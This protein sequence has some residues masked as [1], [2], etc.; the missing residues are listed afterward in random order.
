MISLIW[1][2]VIAQLRAGRSAIP[3]ARSSAPR[4]EFPATMDEG[5]PMSRARGVEGQR[6]SEGAELDLFRISGSG[7]L[8]LLEERCAGRQSR[9]ATSDSGTSFE[10]LAIRRDHVDLVDSSL[11]SRPNGFHS[12]PRVGERS[13]VALCALKHELRTIRRR[14]LVKSA[15]EM[16]LKKGLSSM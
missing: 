9:V 15:F 3:S 8:S 14:V 6:C 11:P 2:Q 13:R 4:V 1:R 12:S 5:S 10:A 16:C 7:A